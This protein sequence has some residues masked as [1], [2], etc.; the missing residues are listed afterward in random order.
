MQDNSEIFKLLLAAEELVLQELVDYLQTYFIENK[1]EWMEQHFE[2]IHRTSFQSNS[3]L[4]LQQFCTDL[5]AKSPEKIFKSLDFTSLPEKS[6]VSLIKRDDLQMKEIEVW[7]HVLKWGLEKNPT[8]LP[9]PV[10]WLD[11][12]FKIMK[13]TLLN[14]LPLIR[15]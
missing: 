5:M 11:D 12:D 7:E 3:L 9:D 14:C 10:T 1:T 15:F 8:L 2:L 4:Q 13:N 6:L